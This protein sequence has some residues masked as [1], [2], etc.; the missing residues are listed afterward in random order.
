[1]Q[2]AV[3]SYLENRQKADV[4]I[5]AH[6]F[7]F[8]P[9]QAQAVW[10]GLGAE[11]PKVL[12]HNPWQLAKLPGF[13]FIRADTLAK[14]L[15][16]APDSTA[17][18]RAALQHV[19]L[20]AA[21]AEGH[22]YLPESELLARTQSL[23]EDVAKQAGYGHG[24]ATSALPAVLETFVGDGGLAADG[25]RVYLG[26]L[27]LAEQRVRAWL[28]SRASADGGLLSLVQAGFLVDQPDLVGNLD[29][30]QIGAVVLALAMPASVLTGGP[31]TGKTTTMRAVVKAIQHALPKSTL[32]LAAPTARAAK[33]LAEVTGHHACT[34]H[35]LLDF[36]PGEK[37]R[38]G[39]RRHRERPLEGSYLIVDE[40]SMMGIELMAALVD[41]VPTELPVLFVGDADQ[42]PPVEA[43]AP[44]HAIARQGTLP[45]VVLERI[46]RTGDGSAISAAARLVNQ[47]RA[48]KAGQ[49]PGLQ[50]RVY[51]R[52]PWGLPK[53][54]REERARQTRA[55]MAD[56]VLLAVKALIDKYGFSRD[57]VQFLTPIHRGPCG[58]TQLNLRL[59]DILNPGGRDRGVFEVGKREF[60]LGDRVVETDNDENKGVIN[61]DIGYVV[62]TDGHVR[63]ADRRGNVQVRAGMLVR[64]EDGREVPYWAG[65]AKRLRLA[66][67]STVHGSQGTEHPAVVM[68]TGWDAYPLLQREMVY[69]GMTRAAR[70][71]IFLTEHGALEKAVA[72]MRG[73]NRYQAL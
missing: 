7:G 54:E 69:T 13:G 23:L 12:E 48:P 3:I 66:Y 73:M 57:G 51:P 49:Q 64:F 20:E 6:A 59:R 36:G 4:L 35:R 39:P 22:V 58:L 18:L 68:V 43:G 63:V 45:T 27:F 25:E 34:L 30:V 40:S 31:G 8:G 10:D 71:L 72:T 52:P 47:G 5:W 17:R 42:L 50:I 67:A 56:D 9:A 38:F 28:Q 26:R 21:R 44:F 24:S 60:W 65:D 16:V 70:Y 29:E 62:S 19:L 33:R 15:G 46:Y 2:D 41:A 11:A 55:K 37:G 1:M 53:K 61:G 14:Q 32:L